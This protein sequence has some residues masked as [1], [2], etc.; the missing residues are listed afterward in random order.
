MGQAL[1]KAE[2]PDNA[3]IWCYCCEAFTPHYTFIAETYGESTFYE[4]NDCGC[5]LDDKEDE[6][7]RPE[8]KHEKL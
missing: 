6:I 8:D 1:S 5:L 3:I 7:I 4:C 2:D